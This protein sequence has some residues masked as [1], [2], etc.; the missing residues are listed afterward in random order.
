MY[1]HPGVLKWIHA[2]GWRT[3]RN[4]Q[5]QAI[6]PIL[7][8][9]SDVLISA[10]TAGGKT[11]AAFL[12]I[13]SSLAGNP[14]RGVGCICISPLRALISDQARR[15]ES[16]CE[17]TGL[18]VQPWHGDVTAGKQQFWKSPAE[19]LLITPESLEAMFLHRASDLARVMVE[20]RYVV[21]DELHAL[22][23][24]VRGR[25]MQSLL[26][27][28]DTLLGRTTPRIALSATFGDVKLAERFLRPDGALPCISLE[29]AQGGG[30]LRVQLRAFIRRKGGDDPYQTISDHLFSVLRGESNLVFA[31]SRGLVEQVSD[32]LRD[33]SERAHVPNEFFPH[34]G[35]LSR[36]QRQWLEARLRDAHLPTTAVC[37]STLELGVDLGDVESVAQIGGA[38]TVSALKQRL[39]RSG[40]RP[41]KPQVLRQYVVLGDV[42]VDSSPGERLRLPL[43]QA[44]A[45]V[46]LML[47]RRFEP[48]RLN[49]DL[50]YSTLVQQVLSVIVQNRGARADQLYGLLCKT[51]PFHDIDTKNFGAFL[52]GLGAT[53]VLEQLGDGT[54]VPGVSGERLLASHD[55]YTAFAIPEEFRL[56]AGG[57][58]LGTLPIDSPVAP[59][60]LI[61]FGGRRWRIAHADINSKT[62]TLL[63]A[64]AGK[65]PLF[66]GGAAAVSALLRQG[67]SELLRDTTMPVYLDEEAQMQLVAARS[68]F[69]AMRLDTQPIY[70]EDSCLWLAPWCSDR[71]LNVLRLALCSL[72]LEATNEDAFVSVSNSTVP[73]VVE[74]LDQWRVQG[75]PSMDQLLALSLPIVEQKFDQ[76]VD[77]ALRL[78][79]FGVR[80]LDFD[81]ATSALARLSST[82]A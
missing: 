21:S 62:L 4:I 8:R 42:A 14:P 40:R 63:P 50:H 75:L 77:T 53:G 38:P 46:E 65:V 67:M 43:I 12:P 24:S 19:I 56:V 55:L 1:L 81:E 20:L 71:A 11:E 79:N 18:R 60:M 74:A 45:A 49:D 39:G 44:I 80:H 7:D 16:L 82:T 35:S 15:L 34:H 9:Q 73:T 5:E 59:G 26:H 52:R 61:I 37:T 28:L 3:L 69:L 70:A 58:P 78:Q 68:E 6:A 66:G 23:G 17:A 32:D 2:R 33:R 36:D 47:Q 48:P 54:L 25:Q 31:N 10:P 29:G 64:P 22:V 57:K 41:G 27:R 13:V 30:E 51:G 72:G 76:F